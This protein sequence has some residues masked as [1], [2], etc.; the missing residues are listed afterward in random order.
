LDEGISKEKCVMTRKIGGSLLVA[1]VLAVV[2]AVGQTDKRTYSDTVTVSV[3]RNRGPFI[4]TPFLPHPYH[5]EA[6][7]PKPGCTNTALC[8]ERFYAYDGANL[9]T[10]A[11]T[12]WQSQLMGSISGPTDNAQ[13]KY[14]GLTNTAITP[15]M[16]DT[17]LSGLITS[18]GLSCSVADSFNDT[19]GVVAVP[20]TP[21]AAVVG[22]TGAVT[23]NYWVMASSQGI[24]T[25]LTATSNQLT[26]A[27]ATLSTTNYNT[28]TFTG[29][30]GATGYAV[31]RTTSGTPPSGTVSDLVGGN[32]SCT[33]ALAC[34]V[35]DQSN[36]LT[37]VTIPAS[38]LTNY[39]HFTLVKTWTDT[40]A[41]QSAQAFGIF[42]NSACTSNMR[43]EGTF[44]PVSLNVNDTFQ[45]T[46]TIQFALITAPMLLFSML[47]FPGF[48][49][50]RR[51]G[52]W[53]KRREG[54]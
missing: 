48:L 33:A 18:N 12:T 41:G 26:T 14:M 32:A 31:L 49:L 54:R 9:R 22:T 50:G 7:H 29:S 45:L 19:S 35:Y 37:S 39:G 43:F 20:G 27:N 3:G 5:V 2:I 51:I 53:L 24:Y 17:A 40:T 25:T 28:I 1:A 42:T 16:A 6:R 30:A 4:L 47:W 11:G 23:Y 34:T 21:T 44:T 8:G 36:T 52:F 15:A 13:A 38:N 10:S 46:E